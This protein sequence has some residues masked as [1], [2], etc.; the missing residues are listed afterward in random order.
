MR[1]C[2]YVEWTKRPRTLLGS[3]FQ[4]PGGYCPKYQ[5]IPYRSR[6]LVIIVRE[7]A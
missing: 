3:F 7:F 6:K 1:T 4:H 5:P 2:E